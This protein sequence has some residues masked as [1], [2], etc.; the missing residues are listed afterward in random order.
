MR[1]LAQRLILALFWFVISVVIT[2]VAPGA[3]GRAVARLHLTSLKICALGT[4]AFLFLAAIMV[5]GALVLPNYL[6]VTIGLMT[7]LLMML[8]Y[9]FGRVSLQVSV[10]KMIQKHFSAARGRSETVAILIGVC[11]WTSILSVPYLWIVA[12][13]LIFSFGLGLILTGRTSLKWQNP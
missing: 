10:G 3:I 9:V 5:A 2:T 4:T 12:L 13:M 8:A 6:S 7:M 1:F 11:V